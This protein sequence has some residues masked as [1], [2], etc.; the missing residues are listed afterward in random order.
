[1]I[2]QWHWHSYEIEDARRYNYK[3]LGFTIL[4][5]EEK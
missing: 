4:T 5:S 3:E 2:L 1:M